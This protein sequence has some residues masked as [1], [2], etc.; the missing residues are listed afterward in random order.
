MAQASKT[1]LLDKV[2]SPADI[3]RLKKKDL[4]QLADELRDEMID[5]VTFIRTMRR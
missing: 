2:T 4:R 5:V 1:P 3:R